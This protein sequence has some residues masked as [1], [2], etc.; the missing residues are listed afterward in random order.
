M[1]RWFRFY[2]DAI[3]DPKILKLSD[4]LFRFWV[5][6]L[7]LASKKNGMLPA[8][9]EIALLLRMKSNKVDALFKNLITAG[10]IDID[11]TGNRPHNWVGRQYKSDVTDPTAAER[12]RRY[13]YGKKRNATVTVKR[14]DTDTD[15]DTDTEK[16][17]TKEA[18][19]SLGARKRATRLSAEWWPTL[20]NVD[21][22]IGKGLNQQRINVEAEK[23]RNYWIAKS[24]TGAT[25]LDWD[26]TWQNWILNAC[27]RNGAPGNGPTGE[28]LSD[29]AFQLA[30]RARSAE[31]ARGVDRPAKPVGSD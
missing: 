11:E 18:G 19:A 2:D 25:K 14:P 9:D 27:E 6:I 29:R 26:A 7:C 10:L 1:S 17:E 16:K 3:N 8:N 12:Q 28:S 30:E 23:F 31:R 24:G 20:E 22:A 15:T 13:R 4:K 21:Y 5:G